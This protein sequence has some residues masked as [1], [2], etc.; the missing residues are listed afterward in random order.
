MSAALSLSLV[1]SVHPRGSTVDQCP[2]TILLMAA[3]FPLRALRSLLA[4][5]CC[6]NPPRSLPE[7]SGCLRPARPTSRGPSRT[8]LRAAHLRRRITRILAPPDS[9]SKRRNLRDR[10]ARIDYTVTGSEFPV[11]PRPLPRSAPLFGLDEARRRLKLRTPFFLRFT[12]RERLPARLLHQ[13]PQQTRARQL[14]RPVPF[15]GRRRPLLRRRARPLQTPPLR[16]RP[17]ALS[18][19]SRLRLRR[20]EISASRPATRP[21]LHRRSGYAPEAAAVK[22]FFDTGGESIIV[23][24]G[25]AREEPPTALHFERA[26]EFHAQWHKVKA[27]QSLADELV[28]PIP[29][30]RAVIVQKGRTSQPERNLSS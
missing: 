8:S 10:V 13:P 4:G 23:A 19:T 25:L 12:C 2:T 14:L 15:A 17:R 11:L 27:A 30:L 21:T 29:N 24:I 5:D 1:Y 6:R 3:P 7:P 16:R 26:A 22:R 20:D 18:R 9:Q 28:Q